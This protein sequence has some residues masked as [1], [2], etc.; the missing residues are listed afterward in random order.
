MEDKDWTLVYSSDKYHQVEIIK[1]ILEENGIE[2][3]E[4]DKRDSSYVIF[5]DID[6]YVNVKDAPLARIIIEKHPL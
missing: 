6:L 4:V 5:G 3:F 1:A 2:S